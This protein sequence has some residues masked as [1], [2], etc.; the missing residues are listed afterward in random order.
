M[1]SYSV[2]FKAHWELSFKI[3]W[4]RQ[5]LVNFTGLVGIVNAM[6]ARTHPIST[7]LGEIVIIC[8]TAM[9]IYIYIYIYSLHRLDSMGAYYTITTKQHTMI[10][11]TYFM[12]I[13]LHFVYSVW[14]L[15]KP[16]WCRWPKELHFCL[17]TTIPL[18][19]LH[20]FKPKCIWL[21]WQNF[22]H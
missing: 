7:G 1:R 18:T 15:W 16:C 9:D 12:G 22:C 3:H 20:G 13:T 19:I 21:Y 2:N 8:T 5:Y 14:I 6:F 10:P 11:R 17:V 4:V